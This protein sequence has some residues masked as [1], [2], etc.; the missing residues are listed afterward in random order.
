MDYSEKNQTKE[1]KF[2]WF[3]A[4]L[5]QKDHPIHSKRRNMEKV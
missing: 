3:Y 1:E 5:E 2:S 4:F